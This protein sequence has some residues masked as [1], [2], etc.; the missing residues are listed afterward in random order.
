MRILYFVERFW[1][2]IG[3]VE[4]LSARILPELARRGFEITVVTTRDGNEL[5][6]RDRFE[7]LDVWRFPMVDAVRENDV[8]AVFEI[9][10]QLIALRRELRPD[11]V[12]MVFTGAGI[13]F[14]VSTARAHPAPTLLSFHGHFLRAELP[15]FA[16]LRQAIEISNWLTA[17]SSSVLDDLRSLDVGIESRSEAILNGL[18]STFDPSPLRLDPPLF[19]CAARLVPEKGIDIAAEALALVRREFPAARLMI[20]GEGPVREVV[21]A[22]LAELELLDAVEFLGPRSPD[23]IAALIDSASIVLVPSR[24]EGFGLIALEGMLGGRPVVASRVG[25]LPEVLG[26]DGGVLVEPEDPE[27]LATAICSLL[28]DPDHAR[29]VADA[30]RRR[31][32][33]RFTL[34]RCVDEHEALYHRLT[35]NHAS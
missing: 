35:S 21:E 5:P 9:R 7:G 26:D 33:A 34:A 13:Y 6:E 20:A 31:A 11:L 29:A 19:L 12:H 32:L 28:R 23:D 1:P 14:P 18:D 10:S 30:G 2:Y 16:V 3:G 27:A 22:R 24:F 17:C 4:V 8:E 15:R 25:G